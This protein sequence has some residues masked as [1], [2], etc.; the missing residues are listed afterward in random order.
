MTP[1]AEQE[2]AAEEIRR[3][4]F[5]VFVA[6]MRDYAAAWTWRN[7]IDGMDLA[8]RADAA[9]GPK[10]EA[11]HHDGERVTLPIFVC[12]IQHFAEGYGWPNTLRAIAQAM[13]AD[14]QFKAEAEARR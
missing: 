7:V 6:A 11:C 9:V 13:E 12:E 10:I 1:L 8:Y 2:R 14:E 3:T 5:E 4:A